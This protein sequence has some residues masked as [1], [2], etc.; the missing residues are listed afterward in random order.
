MSDDL[1]NRRRHNVMMQQRMTG[2]AAQP[3]TPESDADPNNPSATPRPAHS[4]AGAE[5]RYWSVTFAT[6]RTDQTIAQQIVSDAWP[7]VG[8]NQQD[9]E[10]WHGFSEAIEFLIK[11]SAPPQVTD[12]MVT[13]GLAA[14]RACED[15][16]AMVRMRAALTAALHGKE[17]T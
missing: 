16:N 12:E 6:E 9:A 7:E 2:I 17:G 15:Q 8:G 10:W 14:L 3:G 1:I 11:Y 4:P 13:A 5:H